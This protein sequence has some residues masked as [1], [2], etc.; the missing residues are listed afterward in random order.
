MHSLRFLEI[1][2]QELPTATL[3]ILFLNFGEEE[4][5][6][7]YDNAYKYTRVFLCHACISEIQMK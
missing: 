6:K 3:L 2:R 4:L 7:C 5:L 1:Y